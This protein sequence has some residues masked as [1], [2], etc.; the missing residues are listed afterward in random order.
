MGVAG[1]AQRVEQC[2]RAEEEAIVGDREESGDLGHEADHSSDVRRRGDG[3]EEEEEEAVRTDGRPYD[4]TPMRALSGAR[5]A[6][7][8]CFS[9]SSTRVAFTRR[10]N[11]SSAS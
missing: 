4:T 9:T 11:R 7:A 2:D 8:A 6:A 3:R 5:R 10:S 1:E